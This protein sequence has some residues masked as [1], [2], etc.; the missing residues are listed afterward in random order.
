MPGI[1]IEFLNVLGVIFESVFRLTSEN[2]RNDIDNSNWI[3]Y[4]TYI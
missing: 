3:K 1:V 4:F 2:H